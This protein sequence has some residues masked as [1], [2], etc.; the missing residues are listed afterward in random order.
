MMSLRYICDIPLSLLYSIEETSSVPPQSPALAHH[1]RECV[2]STVECE[3]LASLKSTAANKTGSIPST[4]NVTGNTRSHSRDTR[5]EFSSEGTST[6][7]SH[8]DHVSMKPQLKHISLK[9]NSK[10]KVLVTEVHSVSEFW[11]Q[12]LSHDLEVMS[13]KMR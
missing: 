9:I 6:V 8:S 11:V 3:Q 1:R 10:L 5:N 2:P 12:P 4:G 7:A 13:A